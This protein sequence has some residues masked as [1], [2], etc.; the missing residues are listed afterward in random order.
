MDK[1][2]FTRFIDKPEAAKVDGVR[3]TENFFKILREGK[4]NRM[5]I[6]G[7]SQVYHTGGSLKR[8]LDAKGYNAFLNFKS[9]ESTGMTIVRLSKG[10]SISLSLV[11]IL[12]GGNNPS[13]A[14]TAKR[15]PRLVKVINDKFDN[16]EIIFGLTPPLTGRMVPYHEDMQN[17]R[18]EIASTIAN[19]CKENSINFFDPRSF[20]KDPASITG[21]D[22]LHVQGA[23]ADRFASG[24]LSAASFGDATRGESVEDDTSKST[25]DR[26]LERLRL[27]DRQLMG[28]NFGDK[29]RYAKARARKCD[30]AGY[31]GFG[32][33][34]PEILRLKK[35]LSKLG[36]NPDTSND[37]FDT[38][39]LANVV[40]F[41]KHNGLR[42]DG[43]VGPSTADWIL[44]K[45]KKASE[46]KDPNASPDS[47]PKHSSLR[48]NEITDMIY[49]KYAKAGLN[50][51]IAAAAIINS[52]AESGLKYYLVGDG[53]NS[54]GLFQ[55]HRGSKSR[56]FW[57]SAGLD[58]DIAYDTRK[59]FRE[60]CKSQNLP[61][62]GYKC[63]VRASGMKEFAR[64]RERAGDW[65]FNPERNTEAI[66]N[67]EV[68][69][70]AGRK[71]R[72]ADRAGAS[73]P[74]LAAIF[75]RDIERPA[76]KSK[77]MRKRRK[78]ATKKFG[79]RRLP[80][81]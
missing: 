17:K 81:S 69:R 76:N 11:V 72:S 56:P 60:L 53:G 74:E 39:F 75:C 62:G 64:K 63:S 27:N 24:I 26:G 6:A 52:L 32:S 22:G 55:L 58:P 28:L 12:T 13:A 30:A 51:N 35:S 71:L 25:E 48:K 18:Q 61:P 16:P 5:M 33:N 65:R 43:C 41:Q 1:K 54:V 36:Y 50:K 47:K 20:M 44:E 80:D 40:A 15:L 19:F 2:D 23:N 46:K 34:G 29:L 59:Q 9:G 4:S 3:L 78:I 68:K 31:L 66:I 67:I 42:Q 7:D 8:K 38:D 37:S 57:K 49:R 14:Y 70:G 79:N 21:G 45:A 77:G 73:I 10:K